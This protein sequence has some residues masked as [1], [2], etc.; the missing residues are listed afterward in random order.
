[1]MVE[2][3]QKHAQQLFTYCNVGVSHTL[4]F[5]F[6]DVDFFRASCQ[7]SCLH[8]FVVCDAGFYLRVI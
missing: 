8:C 4:T 5:I 3:W 1:M 2:R 7:M 6:Y